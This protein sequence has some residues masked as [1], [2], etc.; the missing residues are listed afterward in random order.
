MNLYFYH[1]GLF[2]KCIHEQWCSILEYV[3]KRK[4]KY[5]CVRTGCRIINDTPDEIIDLLLFTC[6]P[7]LGNTGLVLSGGREYCPHFIPEYTN[8]FKDFLDNRVLIK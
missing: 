2:H 1:N 7:V 6:A 8:L 4:K 3:P 5:T